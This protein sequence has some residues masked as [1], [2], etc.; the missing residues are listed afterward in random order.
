MQK[1]STKNWISHAALVGMLMDSRVSLGMGKDS[2][3]NL[4]EL[5]VSNPVSQFHDA[6][7]QKADLNRNEYM[8][9]KLPYVYATANSELIEILGSRGIYGNEGALSRNYYIQVIENGSVWIKYN[10]ILGSWQIGKLTEEE[11]SSFVDAMAEKL[12]VIATSGN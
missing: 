8:G 7:C 6:I 1:Q 10:P 9:N 4:K 3:K 5:W 12:K 11:Y 2:N